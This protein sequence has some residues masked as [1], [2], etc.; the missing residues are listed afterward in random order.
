MYYAKLAWRTHLDFGLSIIVCGF[1][2][3]AWSLH[4]TPFVPLLLRSGIATRAAMKARPRGLVVD[5]YITF[6][7][8][9]QVATGDDSLR[10]MTCVI[11][12]ND[13]GG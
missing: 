3:A 1:G 2:L 13:I 10:W 8:G 5:Y 11:G 12:E 9:L 4:H 7:C 6:L